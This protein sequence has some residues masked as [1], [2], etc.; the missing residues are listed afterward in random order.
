MFFPEAA[1]AYNVTKL[2]SETQGLYIPYSLKFEVM[3]VIYV[4]STL[5]SVNMQHLKHD[6]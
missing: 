2:I 5:R 6:T 3:D 1:E 4:S